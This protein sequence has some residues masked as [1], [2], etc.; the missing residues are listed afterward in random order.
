MLQ[1]KILNYSDLKINPGDLK[2]IWQTFIHQR[3]LSM[4]LSTNY[5]VA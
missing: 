1:I 3:S 2:P 4:T 5:T